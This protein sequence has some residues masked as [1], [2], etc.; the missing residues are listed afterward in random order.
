[1]FSHSTGAHRTVRTV[2]AAVLGGLALAV[3][4]AFAGAAP[5]YAAGL[6]PTILGQAP[7]TIDVDVT[8]GMTYLVQGDPTPAVTL[9]AGQLPPGLQ[10]QGA[11]LQGVA[12]VPGTYTWT[13]TAHNG[14]GSD[15][16]VTNTTTVVVPAVTIRGNPVQGTVGQPYDF[17]FSLV[18]D[19]APT[20][21]VTYGSL[22]PGLSLDPS[23]RITGV[24]TTAG[25]FG[26]DVT[27]ANDLGSQGM[28]TGITINPAPPSASGTP[29]TG[30]V[31]QPYDFTFT[32]NGDPTPT[33]DIYSGALPPGLTLTPDGHVTGTPTADGGYYV[34]IVAK[35]SWASAATDV[36]FVIQPSAPTGPP[37]GPPTISVAG[38]RIAEGN[39]GT[40]AL[41]FTLTL[42]APSSSPVTVHWRT[43]TG[44]ARAGS[45]YVAASRTATFAPGQTSRTVTVLVKGD[46]MRERDETFSL[47]LSSPVGAVLGSAQAV[48]V[49]VNDD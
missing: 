4:T 15:A 44:T 12:T 45:D 10:L 31:G 47:V 1:M 35:N 34:G 41:T 19:P 18:G 40:R 9:T 30:I 21:T 25:V 24:P 7:A 29:P 49:I 23:G 36:Y 33:V 11:A 46:R 8:F 39:S 3:G 48:G 20:V 38:R 26:F 37:S 5:A 6:A 28:G 2:A 16:S 13:L 14:V 32:L 22:P 43:V 17:T 27:A 42:S